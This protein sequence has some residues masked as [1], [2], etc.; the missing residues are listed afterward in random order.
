MMPLRRCPHFGHGPTPRHHD[1]GDWRPAVC[2]TAG[3][4]LGFRLG[5]GAEGRAR[6]TAAIVYHRCRLPRTRT[7]KLGTRNEG[8]HHL[9]A[10]V[11]WVERGGVWFGLD[12]GLRQRW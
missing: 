2:L 11:A 5:K 6:V 8:T 12:L 7:Q 9:P 4:Y 3:T 10:P 1:F